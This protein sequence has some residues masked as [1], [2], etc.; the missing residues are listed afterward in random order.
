MKTERLAAS[1]EQ[2]VF[3]VARIILLSVWIAS[4]S[5]NTI[6]TSSSQI[7]A[8]FEKIRE[9]ATKV[10]LILFHMCC[11]I[12]LVKYFFIDKIN[13]CISLNFGRADFRQNFRRHNKSTKLQAVLIMQQGA[14]ICVLT[15]RRYA[16]ITVWY[17]FVFS[18]VAIPRRYI[19]K[20]GE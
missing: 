5:K 1:C 7:Y 10:H 6:F 16:N 9:Y 20:L 13:S 14:I 17:F 19:L 18:H 11:L 15:Y 3:G 12:I 8:S 2:R 4:S